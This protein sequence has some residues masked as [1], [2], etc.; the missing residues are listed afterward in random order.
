[1]TENSIEIVQMIDS[2]Q[3]EDQ[4]LVSYAGDTEDLGEWIEAVADRYT[5]TIET[6]GARG[7]EDYAAIVK[8][9]PIDDGGRPIDEPPLYYLVTDESLRDLNLL[10]HWTKYELKDSETARF[11][12]RSNPDAYI[13]AMREFRVDG[14]M[15]QIFFAQPEPG[16]DPDE[17]NAWAWGPERENID[18]TDFP[19]EELEDN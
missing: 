5:T 12:Y 11:D 1:M 19:D 13:K 4:G 3:W 2:R 6:H 14:S 17:E 9:Q 10:K 18:W 15:S 8:L 7:W 16:Q